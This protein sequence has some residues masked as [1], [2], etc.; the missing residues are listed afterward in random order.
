MNVG[1][2]TLRISYNRAVGVSVSHG[3]LSGVTNLELC[4]QETWIYSGITASVGTFT[5]DAC[6]GISDIVVGGRWVTQDIVGL[7]FGVM[8]EGT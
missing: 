4:L 7:I 8:S 5:S 2:G 1:I 3:R 6:L